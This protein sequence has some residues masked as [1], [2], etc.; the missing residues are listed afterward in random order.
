MHHLNSHLLGQ[1]PQILHTF[2]T[3]HGGQSQTPYNS[4][5]IAFHVGD[6]EKD[7]LINHQHL[8]ADLDYDLNRLIHM[9]QIHSD[10]V[11]IVDDTFDFTSPPECDALVTNTPELPL[12]VM[13]ADCT[14]ILLY[15]PKQQVIAAVHAGRAGAFKNILSKTVTAM[16]DSFQSNPADI[17]AVLGASICQSCYEVNKSIYEEAK[18]VKLDYALQKREEKYFLAVK[19]ILHKQLVQAGVRNENI[20]DIDRCSACEHAH[21]FSYRA[22]RGITGRMAGLIMLKR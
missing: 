12:M 15:D 16:H 6:D 14:P 5:N 7:V 8:A 1:F 3:R 9:R 13:V 11:M 10:H 20:E 19:A 2:S 21:F 17:I 4:N 22:D 18:R